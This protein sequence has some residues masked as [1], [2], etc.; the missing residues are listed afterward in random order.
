[1]DFDKALFDVPACRIMLMLNQSVVVNMGTDKMMTL[2]DLEAL[3]Q[4][5]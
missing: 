4:N 2:S 5:G 3:K 1:M